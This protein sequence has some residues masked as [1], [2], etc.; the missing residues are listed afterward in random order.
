MIKLT[1]KSESG[2]GEGENW[3]NAKDVECISYNCFTQ[4]T[5]VETYQGKKHN[6]SISQKDVAHMVARELEHYDRI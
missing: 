4:Q 1:W 5:I 3:V 2:D 6:T